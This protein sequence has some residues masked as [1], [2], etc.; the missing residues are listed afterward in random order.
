MAVLRMWLAFTS[1]AVVLCGCTRKEQLLLETRSGESAAVDR[2]QTLLLQEEGRDQTAEEQGQTGSSQ[3]VRPEEE[4]MQGVQPG[5]NELAD[6]LHGVSENGPGR[7]DGTDDAQAR[8][9]CVH[10]CGAVKKAGVYELPFGSRVYEAVE[11]A[12]GFAENADESYVNQAQRL[13]DGAKLMIPTL[14]QVQKAMENPAAD[15]IGIIEQSVVGNSD[16]S[17]AAVVRDSSVDL[18]IHPDGKINI[19]T[20]TEAQLC[21][22]PGIGATRAAAIAAYRQEHGNFTSI[23]EIMRVNGIKEGTYEKMKDSITVN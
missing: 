2:E 17:G 11:Q 3:T 19:N 23:E 12:G 20:A 10:V 1:V 13:S 16:G 8:T 5:K 14:E 4:T 6:A 21:E 15:G 22:I 7:Q 9:I 18:S